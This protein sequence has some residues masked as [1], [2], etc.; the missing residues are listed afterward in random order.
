MNKRIVH[1]ALILAAFTVVLGLILGA[2]YGLTRTRI[3]EEAY[4]KEQKAYK[5][6][7]ENADSFTAYSFD[8][9]MAQ[10]LMADNNFK[11][12]IVGVQVAEDETGL[13]LGYVISVTAKDGSQ[14]SI[15]LSVGIQTNGTVNGYAITS[16]AET[17]GLGMKATEPEFKDQFKDKSETFFSVVKSDAKTDDQ[18]TAITGSTITSKAVANAVNASICYFLGLQSG[19]VQ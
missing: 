12:E 4:K 10:K 1:D 2:V 8:K 17:P 6:V 13:V 15:T 18:I 16:I 5:E 7:F 11:D 9:D 19:E 14:G 3:E